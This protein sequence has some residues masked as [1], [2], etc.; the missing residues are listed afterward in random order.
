M[1]CDEEDLARSSDM[2]DSM[3]DLKLYDD[4]MLVDEESTPVSATKISKKE[5]TCVCVI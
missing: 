5:E 2:V 1:S 3:D 4:G